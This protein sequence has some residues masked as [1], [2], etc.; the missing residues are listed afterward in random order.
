MTACRGALDAYH[1]GEFHS[2]QHVGM[3]MPEKV[4]DGHTHR[5]VVSAKYPHPSLGDDILRV[6]DND[7]TPRSADETLPSDD[8]LV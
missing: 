7:I 2:S 1:A 4:L 3:Y 6:F 8:R 5:A